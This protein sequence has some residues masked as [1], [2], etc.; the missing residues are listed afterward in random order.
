LI[1]TAAA[2]NTT[3]WLQQTQRNTARTLGLH[4]ALGLVTVG[5]RGDLLVVDGRPDLDATTLRNIEWVLVDGVAQRARTGS[6]LFNSA[7]LWYREL[8]FA[9][10]Y[11][12]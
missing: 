11:R 2:A 4:D 9:W 5:Y 10:L 8:L 3:H 1:S 12:S 6:E 7:V